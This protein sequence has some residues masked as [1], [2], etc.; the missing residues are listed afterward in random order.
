VKLADISGKK[1]K[2]EDLE[3][4]SKIKNI[5][6]LYRGINDFQKGYH[7]RTNVKKYENGDMVA[8][9]YSI[10]V[11]WRKYFPQ[12]LNVH[13][14]NDVRHTEVHTAEPLVPEP[15]A[16][17]VELAIEKLKKGKNDQVLIK[18]QQN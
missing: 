1:V 15:S 5:R 11:R 2:I 3:N 8:D 9:P 12:L 18:S 7:F 13:G 16:F 14:V 10:A 6:D 17:D 4:S